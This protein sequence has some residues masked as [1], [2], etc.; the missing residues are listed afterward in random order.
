MASTIQNVT[1]LATEAIKNGVWEVKSEELVTYVSVIL[2][3]IIPLYL[4][5]KMSLAQKKPSVRE[6]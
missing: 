3:A 4:G 5:C 2:L 6:E 1:R